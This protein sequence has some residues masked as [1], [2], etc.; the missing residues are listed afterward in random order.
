[1]IAALAVLLAQLPSGVQGVVDQG[2]LV[3]RA[4][5]IEVGR[6]TFRLVTQRLAAGTTGWLLDASAR[7]TG[8]GR[9]V[10]YAPVLEIGQDSSTQALSF[11]VRGGLAPQRITGQP[12]RDRFTLRYLSVGVER[13]R[14]LPADSQTV[15]V[16]DSVFAP[17]LLVAWRARTAAQTMT[18][19]YPRTAT[20]VTLQARDLGS[21]A[22]TLNRD[23]ATLRHII[24]TGGRDGPVHLW[25]GSKDRLMKIEVPDRK[26]VVERLPG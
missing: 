17:F 16:D 8:G 4:D 23:P 6:E 26:L 11:D 9:V 12:G 20:R 22:T 25:L 19:V 14:E 7:W 2:V 18:A 13:A 21:E 15:I 10:V 3:I 5:T 1:M 24:V